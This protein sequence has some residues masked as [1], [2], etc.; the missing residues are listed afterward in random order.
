M[1]LN[2][3][4]GFNF[5]IL[6][7]PFEFAE[8]CCALFYFDRNVVPYIKKFFIGRMTEL[9]IDSNLAEEQRAKL[10]AFFI[11]KQGIIKKIEES[12]NILPL[13]ERQ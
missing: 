7:Y 12:S 6:I 5:Q 13:I 11:L 8:K 3:Y 10:T 2:L 1:I 9:D 4:F